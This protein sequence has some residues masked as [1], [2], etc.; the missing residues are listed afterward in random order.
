VIGRWVTITNQ[1]LNI[2]LTLHGQVNNDAVD[3]VLNH[4]DRCSRPELQ[5]R[6]ETA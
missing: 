4:P 6:V 2:S 1:T 3:D 5:N